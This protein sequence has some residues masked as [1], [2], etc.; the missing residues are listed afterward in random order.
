M[1]APYGPFNY[2]LG[3]HADQVDQNSELNLQV[4]V[5]AHLPLSGVG[6]NHPE[7]TQG[8]SL[9]LWMYIQFFFLSI[10]E[11]DQPRAP[12]QP[13]KYL[14]K[15]LSN[16]SV[17]HLWSESTRG[18]CAILR[19]TCVLDPPWCVYRAHLAPC[20]G[21]L[22]SQ[23]NASAASNSL[24]LCPLTE[25]TGRCRLVALKGYRTKKVR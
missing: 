2:S 15:P 16:C 22:R 10:S 1:H 20:T 21:L 3:F 13:Y 6:G 17:D 19:N 11:A 7:H 14:R 8:I 12:D 24:R 18:W 23:A 9:A 5:S 4:V 25:Y